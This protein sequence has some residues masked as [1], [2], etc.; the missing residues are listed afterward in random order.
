MEDLLLEKE[1]FF[2]VEHGSRMV[3]PG[4]RHTRRGCR[5]S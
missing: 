5:E 3:A 2:M 4:Y 1:L